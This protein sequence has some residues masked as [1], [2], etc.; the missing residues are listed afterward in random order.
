MEQLLYLGI[1]PLLNENDAVSGNQGFVFIFFFF[2][3]ILLLLP[4]F[5]VVIRYELF[6]NTFSD[7]DSLAAIVASCIHAQV[8]SY[9]S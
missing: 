5:V 6:C 3:C 2:I 4:L 1:V 9:F 7:N 8:L